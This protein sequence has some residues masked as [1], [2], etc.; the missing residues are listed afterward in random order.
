MRAAHRSQL[1]AP[2]GTGAMLAVVG[3]LLTAAAVT[4]GFLHEG[5]RGAGSD[6]GP[7]PWTTTMESTSGN[8][9]SI[10]SGLD[11]HLTVQVMAYDP[12]QSSGWHRHGVLTSIDAG[13]TVA[14]Y[15]PA[16]PY[17]GGREAHLAVN[18]ADVPARLAVTRVSDGRVDREDGTVVVPAPAGC[19]PG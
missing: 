15:T 16:V 17:V 4:G 14:T 5:A 8:Q 19:R 13:C 10:A 18:D 1:R 7:Q 2:I 6:N 11:S 12:G 3:A 9:A